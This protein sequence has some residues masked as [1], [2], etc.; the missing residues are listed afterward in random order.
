VDSVNKFIYLGD[1]LGKGG[2]VEEANRA[3]VKIPW[4]SSGTLN[5]INGEE[6]ILRLNRRAYIKSRVQ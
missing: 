2:G 1:M 6:G 4:E 5:D 3:R